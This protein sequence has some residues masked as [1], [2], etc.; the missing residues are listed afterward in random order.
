MNVATNTQLTQLLT[1]RKVDS[2][3]QRGAELDIDFEDGSTLSLKLSGSAQ[4]VTLT[5]KNDKQE[6]SA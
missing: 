4:S 1:G 6:Y 2:V 5:D 3:R